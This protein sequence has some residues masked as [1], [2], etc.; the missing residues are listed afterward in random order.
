[1][2]CRLILSDQPTRWSSFS[3]KNVLGKI[4]GIKTIESKLKALYH[5]VVGQFHHFSI[6]IEI[7]QDSNPV[8]KVHGI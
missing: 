3:R 1:M 5:T 6:H 4:T 8:F 7:I 2:M